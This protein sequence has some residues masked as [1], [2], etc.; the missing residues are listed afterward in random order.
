[1]PDSLLFPAFKKPYEGAKGYTLH[2]LTAGSGKRYTLY[3]HDG[4]RLYI[5]CLKSWVTAGMPV[6]EFVRRQLLLLVKYLN[7]ASA[8]VISLVPLVTN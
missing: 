8:S 5:W 1:M 2:V 7:P 6:E 4:V 3:V